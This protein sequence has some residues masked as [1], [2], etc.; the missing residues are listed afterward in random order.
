MASVL[1]GWVMGVL[2]GG[3]T[4]G[5]HGMASFQTLERPD[6]SSSLRAMRKEVAGNRLD[7][8]ICD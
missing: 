6:A 5:G 7:R 3:K 2:E 1:E 4:E 8:I